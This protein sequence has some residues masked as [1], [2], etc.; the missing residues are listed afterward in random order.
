[1]Y[2]MVN[3]GYIKNKNKTDMNANK[4]T[5]KQR[6]DTSYEVRFIEKNN[7]NEYLILQI[8]EVYPPK[9]EN[10]LPNLWKKL[11]FT[12]KILDNYYILDVCVID[13][14]GYEY[15]KYNPQIAKNEDGNREINFDYML[16]VS[17]ANMYKLIESVYNLFI[18]NKKK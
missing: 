6:T 11:G 9:C 16:E 1:M 15:H 12:D 7:L 4:M 8:N 14:N 13:E 17:E 18:N 10:S 3:I 5:L 2:G